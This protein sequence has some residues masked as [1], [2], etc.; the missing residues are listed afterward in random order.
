M[1]FITALGSQAVT[2]ANATLGIAVPT[3]QVWRI[4]AVNV[5]QPAAGDAKVVQLAIGTTATA[6]NIKRSYS[7]AAGVA[8]AQDF[9]QLVMVAADQ[10]NV[11]QVG[12]TTAQAV[13]TVTVAKDLIT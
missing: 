2:T 3:G 4:T 5:Q 6:V 7:L 12:G 13:I 8:V 10:V 11:V 1:S 9:P